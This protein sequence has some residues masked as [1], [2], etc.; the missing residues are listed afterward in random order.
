[1]RR[2]LGMSM[3]SPVKPSAGI[4]EFTRMNKSAC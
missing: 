1:M 4:P 2:A 3:E